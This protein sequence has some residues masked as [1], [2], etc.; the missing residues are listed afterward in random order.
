[1]WGPGQLAYLPGTII[2]DKKTT[3]DR[4]VYEL[5]TAA[6]KSRSGD[7]VAATVVS[8]L[9]KTGKDVLFRPEKPIYSGGHNRQQTE[10]QSQE[11]P[12]VRQRFK[13]G[14]PLLD[15]SGCGPPQGI[16]IAHP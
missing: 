7:I 4:R 13:L 6:R 3:V 10:Q 9:L 8:D 11:A 15:F 5:V 1:M 14:E 2:A 16:R 12:L